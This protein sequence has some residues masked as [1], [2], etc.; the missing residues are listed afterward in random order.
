MVVSRTV[1]AENNARV[2][3]QYRRQ[4]YNVRAISL[5]RQFKSPGEAVELQQNTFFEALC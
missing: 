5:L 4:T 1:V 2:I 3:V